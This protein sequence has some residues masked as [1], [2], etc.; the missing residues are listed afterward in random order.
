MQRTNAFLA[1]AALALSGSAA[2]SG[3][4]NLPRNTAPPLTP[5]QEA[6]EYYN[7]GLSYRDKADKLEKE[8]LAETQPAK[9]ARLL[10]KSRSRHDDSIK[11]FEKAVAKDPK[12]YQA[13]GSLGYAY[14][15]TGRYPTALE[16]YDKALGLQ[17]GYT[18]AIE[19]RAEAYLNLNRLADVKAAYMTLFASDRAR[20][21]ELSAAMDKWLEKR[22]ADAAGLDPAVLEDFGRWVADRRQLAS[23]T[24]NL[25]GTAPR[26]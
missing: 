2:A 26:W 13:W 9:Q 17:P 4:R 22:R 1:A 18:P 21:D 12:L 15:K 10:E 3:T 11:K 19:Y 14:R 16:A 24:S 25:S 20:A 23:Q 7:D 6:V 5:E 8:A